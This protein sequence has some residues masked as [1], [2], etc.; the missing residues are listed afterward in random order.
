MSQP[1]AIEAELLKRIRDFMEWNCEQDASLS[2]CPAE[3][4]CGYEF[5][6]ILDEILDDELE[7]E[8]VESNSDPGLTEGSIKHALGA[9]DSHVLGTAKA[10][11]Q[12]PGPSPALQCVGCGDNPAQYCHACYEREL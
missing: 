7:G 5:I 1:V 10:D 2:N 6:A 3:D 8:P 11:A 4:A 9:R 12:E